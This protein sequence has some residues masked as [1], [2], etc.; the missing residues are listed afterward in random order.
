MDTKE[1][2]RRA[3]EDAIQ[4]EEE[5]MR[6]TVHG[7]AE[8]YGLAKA[9]R[10]GYRKIL[11]RRYPPRRDPTEGAQRVNVFDIGKLRKYRVE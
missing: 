2:I 3:L 10:D 4:W 7:D 5:L 1:L 6:A 9:L 11:K 8:S